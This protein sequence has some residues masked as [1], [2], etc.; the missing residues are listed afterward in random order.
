MTPPP[1]PSPLPS[2]G[3]Q[4]SPLRWLWHSS[5]PSQTLLQTQPQQKGFHLFWLG[6]PAPSVEIKESKKQK[7]DLPSAMALR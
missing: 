3:Y 7:K 5:K 2:F 1:P 4:P 6:Q